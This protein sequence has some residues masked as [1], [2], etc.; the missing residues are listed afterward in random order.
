MKQD[1]YIDADPCVLYLVKYLDNR[2]FYIAG[3]NE[4]HALEKVKNYFIGHY[5]MR[6]PFLSV[7]MQSVKVE[8]SDI[9]W[10]M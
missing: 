10:P 7:V 6:E 2:Q 4:K 3:L 8:R 5:H 9:E 1:P